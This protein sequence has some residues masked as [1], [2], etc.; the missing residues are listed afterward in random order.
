M[1][2]D[3]GLDAGEVAEIFEGDYTTNGYL[4]FLAIDKPDIITKSA[5]DVS[6]GGATYGS[7][8]LVLVEISKRKAY[9]ILLALSKIHL[10]HCKH[11]FQPL[12]WLMI[13]S[14]VRICTW[15]DLSGGD[16]HFDNVSG[17][18]TVFLSG[19]KGKPVINFDGND[20]LA[21]TLIT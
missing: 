10:K 7:K 1:I 8:F 18:P 3:R 9:Q 20:G 19:L 11:G 6:P 12:T 4:D 15:S 13:S 16:N 5:I 14:T 21:K 17:D 2:Y